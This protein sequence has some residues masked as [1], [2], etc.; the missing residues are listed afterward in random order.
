[1]HLPDLE[2]LRLQVDAL[3]THDP[4]GRIRW[5]NEPGETPAPRFFLGRTREGSLWRF[6]HDV[7]P[8]VVR[9]LE[10]LLADE[11]VTDDPRREPVH[12]DAYRLLLREHAPIAGEEVGPAYY[13]PPEIDAPGSAILITPANME[14]VLPR[15]RTPDDD[16]FGITNGL[17]AGSLCAVVVECG[18]AVSICFS[19]RITAQA[20]EAGVETLPP[21]RGRGY[22]SAVVARWALAV[23]ASGRIPLYS[24]S[25]DNVASQGVARRLGLIPYASDFSLG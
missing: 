9:R 23:R 18:R 11:P 17:A 25:W 5:T 6:R 8:D 4:D 24:T 10:T 14:H 16:P 12:L 20:C 13:F 2:L 22:A 19:S 7:P 21:F 3:L 1:M 15:M